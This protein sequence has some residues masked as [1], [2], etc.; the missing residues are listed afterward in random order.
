MANLGD[1]V[2]DEITGFVGIAIARYSYLQGCDRMCV[3]PVVD[4]KGILPK[5]KTF[6]EPQLIVVKAKKI[7]RKTVAE[8]PGG[9]E[10][11]MPQDRIV[12]TR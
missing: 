2:K 10:K 6:D 4:E 1:E 12:D 11:Y 3:Q 5:E 8:N 9:P 7:K